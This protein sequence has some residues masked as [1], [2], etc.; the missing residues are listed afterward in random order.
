MIRGLSDAQADGP[1]LADERLLKFRT[2]VA[3]TPAP[4]PFWS[5]AL[6]D[7]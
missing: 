1:R 3:G 7:A 5:A 4:N 6:E 2:A